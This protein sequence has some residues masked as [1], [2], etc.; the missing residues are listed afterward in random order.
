MAPAG[1][2][3]QVPGLGLAS[4]SVSASHH[5]RGVSSCETPRLPEGQAAFVGA[6]PCAGPQVSPRPYPWISQE[7][8][9][10]GFQHSPKLAGVCS[11]DGLLA[12]FSLVQKPDWPLRLPQHSTEPQCGLQPHPTPRQKSKR[13]AL[14]APQGTVI[15][16]HSPSQGSP[17]H[18][19]NTDSLARNWPVWS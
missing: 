19:T 18:L 6:Q 15:P 8:S 16:D 9:P 5:R 3:A 14:L 2:F 7:P 13:A 17:L 11:S 10:T 12:L 4:G 1:T